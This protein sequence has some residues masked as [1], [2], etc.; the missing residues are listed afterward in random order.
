[1]PPFLIPGKDLKYCKIKQ[2]ANTVIFQYSNEKIEPQPILALNVRPG[3]NATANND[4]AAGGVAGKLSAAAGKV[5]GAITGGA[6]KVA[7]KLPG[8]AGNAVNSAAGKLAS[9]I[10][11]GNNAEVA[12]PRGCTIMKIGN[13]GYKIDIDGI[14]T[15]ENVETANQQPSQSE[16]KEE[17]QPANT[18][19]NKTVNSAKTPYKKSSKKK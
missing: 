13:A 3:F 7:A 4:G 1:M 8:P 15:E 10:G 5:A 14:L 16:I 12:A 18:E 19:E 6:S 17:D 2:G 11:G 9:M